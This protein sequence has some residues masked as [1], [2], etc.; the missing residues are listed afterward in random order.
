MCCSLWFL[1][2]CL[3]LR[4]FFNS[5]TISHL[6]GIEWCA[7]LLWFH[8]FEYFSTVL[9]FPTYE[10][11]LSD[12]LL[13][14]IAALLWFGV[15]VFFSPT[16]FPPMKQELVMCCLF[17]IP[18]LRVF[19]QQSYPIPPIKQGLSDVLLFF[20]ITCQSIFQQSC[21]FLQ[22]LRCAVLWLHV[23]EYFSTVLPNSHLWS[24]DWVMCCSFVIPCVGLIFQQSY[25]IPTKQGLSDVLLLWLHVLEYFQQSYPIPTYESRDWVMCCS[26]VITRV[27]VF[28]TVLNSTYKAGIEW[29]AALLW[30]LVLEYFSV[31][32][33]PPMKFPPVKQGLS[34]VLLFF[35]DYMC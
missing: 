9:Q 12:V 33:F 35:C 21:H 11:G 1:S 19:F 20:V 23:L 31:L 32:Q 22:G 17:V 2:L 16:Q 7:A 5:P 6:T 8:V 27:R 14:V 28:S 18:R 30:F 3:V 4:V 15:R 13:F 34:D 24:R 29:C 25:P 10:Q 26:F